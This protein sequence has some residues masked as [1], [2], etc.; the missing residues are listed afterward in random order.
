ME[1]DNCKK[2]LLQREISNKVINRKQEQVILC[3]NCY[4]IALLIR[5]N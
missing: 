4:K 5:Q 3:D 1:C 2:M